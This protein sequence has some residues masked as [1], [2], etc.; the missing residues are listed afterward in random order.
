MTAAAVRLRRLFFALWPDDATRDA[1]R[2]AT[3]SAVR[4]CGGKPVAPGNYHV[5]LAFLGNVP[6]ERCDAVIAAVRA[7]SLAP[8]TLT[9]DRLGYFEA[10]QVLWFGPS[11]PPELL[12]RFV[13]ELSRGLRGL[14][15]APD[16]RAFHPHLTLARKVHSPPELR[17]PRAVEW[18]V[19]GF[20][21]V[22]SETDPGG[23]RYRV[24]AQFH[25]D[26]PTTA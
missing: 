12:H 17:A 7:L 11:Q 4:H 5:T 3:R 9:L 13:A 6:D 21:L 20:C 22:E 16:P 19:A 25:A 18:P 14:G 1:L 8:L 23:A 10:A 26:F 15:L 24:V 2:R